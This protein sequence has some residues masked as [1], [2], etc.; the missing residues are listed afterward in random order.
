M[1]YEFIATIFLDSVFSVGYWTYMFYRQ[2][3]FESFEQKL[4]NNFG[5][6]FLSLYML[7]AVLCAIFLIYK[8]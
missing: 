5:E 2:D 7:S 8:I 1:M 3:T 4:E 6:F